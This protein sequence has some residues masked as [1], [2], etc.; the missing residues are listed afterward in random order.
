MDLMTGVPVPGIA[1]RQHTSRQS[2]QMPRAMAAIAFISMVGM[3]RDRR[4]KG[5]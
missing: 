2:A 4:L 3:N 1:V 5:K